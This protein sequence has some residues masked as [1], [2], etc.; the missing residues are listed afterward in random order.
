[1]ECSYS[2][3]IS[4]T[5]ILHW[6]ACSALR[7]IYRRRKKELYLF[8]V[9][10]CGPGTRRGTLYQRKL[11]LPGIELQFLDL[12]TSSPIISGQ[13]L[14]SQIWSKSYL[15]IK[16]SPVCIGSA[17]YLQRYN[18]CLLRETD[19]TLKLFNYTH[20]HMHIY[21]YYLRS[22]KFTLN[23][24]KRSYMFR[25]HDHPQGAYIASC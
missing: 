5:S 18:V 3:T 10:V 9:R 1:M 13:Y 12:T 25:S 19:T 16:F 17:K 8:I 7:R 24:L 2:S 11:P 20:Q 15:N 22:I 14:G 6:D 4:L 23:H 21:M